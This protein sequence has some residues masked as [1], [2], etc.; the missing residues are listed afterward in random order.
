VATS[1]EGDV[2][3]VRPSTFWL[4]PDEGVR[5]ADGLI[6]ASRI[7]TVMNVVCTH[8]GDLVPEDC[9]AVPRPARHGPVSRFAAE[10]R[11]PRAP[12]GQI[13]TSDLASVSGS[14][15]GLL[16]TVQARIVLQEL[17]TRN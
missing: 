16:G 2:V 10:L 14:A 12:R 15:D 9:T 6:L 5:T 1:F 3:T 13:R 11:V 7:G 4:R 8:S 17:T